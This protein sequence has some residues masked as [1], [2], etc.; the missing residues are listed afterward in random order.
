MPLRRI[1]FA[2]VAFSGATAAVAADLLPLTTGIYVLAGTPCKGAPN[3]DTMSY[4]GGDNALNTSQVECRAK[5]VSWVG[6]VYTV[7]QVCS[8]IRSGEKFASETISMT[9]PNATSFT[10]SGQSYRFC[11]KRAQF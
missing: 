10:L 5:K 6:K 2:A 4:W 11:G 9:I 3:S 1:V 8:E 7:N